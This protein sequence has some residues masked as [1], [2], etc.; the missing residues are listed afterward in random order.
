MLDFMIV[1]TRTGKKKDTVEIYPKFII[2][3]SNDLMIRGGDFYAIWV[4]DKQS[5]STDEQDALRLIDQEVDRYAKENSGRFDGTVKVLHMWDADSGM[6]D[7]WHKYCQKQMRDYFHMLDECLI[8]A[9]TET[10]KEN[11]SSKR[12]PYA[13]QKGDIASYEQLAST[14]YEPEERQKLE[15]AI[16]S[17]VSGDSRHIQKF[18]VLYGSAGTGK[19][20]M[21]NI[22]QQL[23]EG[24]YSVFDAKAL[25]SSN[26]A[27]ALEAFKSNPLVAIQHD[28]DLSRIEDNTR[29]NS[30]VSHELMTVNEK[31][32]STY[33]NNFQCFLFMGTNKP[34]KIT[35]AKSGL[36]RRLIDISPSG[37]KLPAKKYQSLMNQIQFE[38][39]G[40]AQH[41]L[42]VYQENPHRY[43]NYTPI[44]MMGASNDFYNFVLDSYSVFKRENGTTLK[45]AWE[46]YKEYCEDAKVGY[47]MS[48][49]VFKEE[50]RNYFREFED[51]FN[52]EDGSRVRS[53]Y[54]GFRADKFGKDLLPEK[55]Q[56]EEPVTDWLDLKEQESQFDLLCADCQAQYASS[57]EKPYQAWD[58]VTTKLKDLDTRKLHYVRAD[59][60]HIMIDFDRKDAEGKKS[61]VLNKQ[62][63]LKWPPTY[64]ELSKGGEGIH[65]HY[66]YTGDVSKLKNIFDENVEIKV[67]TGKA[68]FRRKLTKCN[69]LAIATISS[70]L[71]ERSKNV[72]NFD[73]IK[74]EEH[75]RNIIKK[76]LRK[77]IHPNTT[78]SVS[79]I[80]QA[81]D[82]AYASG[83]SYDVQDLYDEIFS[84]AANSHHQADACIKAVGEMHFKSEE[85]VPAG[86]DNS[87]DSL[88][89]YDVECFPNLF[90][91][92]LKKQG[93]EYPFYDFYN[94]TPSQ[95]EFILNR[96]LIGFNCKHYDNHMLYGSYLGYNN[97]QMFQLSQGL[98]ND[99]LSRDQKPYFGQAYNI[100]YTDIYD[101]CATK[102]SLKKWEIQ[103]GIHHQELGLPWD[104]PVPKEKWPLVAQY[105]HYDVEATEATWDATQA[106]FLA[107]KILADLAGGTVNDS[108]NSLTGKIIFGNEKNPQ[109]EF[110]YRDLAEPVYELDSE[111]LEFLKEACPEMMESTHGE[112]KSLLPYFPGYTFDKFKKE[113]VYREEI[114]G[115]GGEVYA[116]EGIF[117]WVALLDVASMHPHSAIAEVLFGVR[118]TKIF[119]EIVEGRVS[120]KHKAWSELDRMLGGK[121]KPYIQEV[122]DGK[123]TAKDL[124]YALK[125]AINAVYGQTAAKYPNLFKD[126][127][128][129]DN[130]VAKRGALF[131]IDLKYEVQKR[132]FTVAHIKTDSIKIPNATPEIIQ[133]VMWFGKRYGYTFE[134]EATY[135]KMCLV[136]DAVY[137]AKYAK[138]EDCEK[139][140]GYIPGDNSD[141]GGEWTATG[142][143]FQIPYVFKSLF[144]KEPFDFKDLCETKSVKTYIYL[145]M[146]EDFPDVTAQEKELKKMETKYRKGELSDTTITDIRKQLEPEIEKGH[147]YKFVGKVG[148]FCPMK[149]G[150]GGGLLVR[151]SIGADGR[152]KYD[153]VTGTKGFR[154]MESEMVRELHKENDIDH[155]YYHDLCN[156]A[157]AAINKYG[158]FTWFAS[159]DLTRLPPPTM[160]EWMNIPEEIEGEE[161]PFN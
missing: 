86:L 93:K 21:L 56:E 132:G 26:N 10:K 66:I 145:D 141:H 149:P 122:I 59:L 82:D 146:N 153:A 150:S 138:P 3:K 13:L 16:G 23:F 44:H 27:F 37:K 120:I 28:G 19:S 127:R 11:Y 98:V 50:L 81:L 117:T 157:I 25:G 69:D 102:Q 45:A 9:N 113:S 94:P 30:L 53:Y 1:A 39:G 104:Q 156:E 78:P 18:V 129:I 74:D 76:A 108:T 105:C 49:R 79:M 161:I 46:M 89:F 29:L 67:C 63:A 15:W 143:Q 52:G 125:I 121:L 133:F 58:K 51:R 92:S 41:C 6:V 116:E 60:Q 147:Y 151:E 70:G 8:F 80:K 33:Q 38:L 31:F 96:K 75:L 32:K 77:E 61:F 144:T 54:S 136:N 64:A 103:L 140:Y 43:D 97:D 55:K 107:R 85:P 137:V 131:M 42:E 62:E 24:Y 148:Q 95:I 34:V 5:W 99:D 119:R 128:N 91:I 4:E 139:L 100:S 130:I 35:D 88:W 71:P 159:D 123:Y 106:D 135:E 2:K 87:D 72:V 40:I 68:S 152:T 109:K 14:L 17:I 47:P 101:Y 65:L 90:F 155:G 20:T 114:V 57:D 36:I 142:T 115:E 22:I 124:A 12:L 112:A 110:H 134:H 154:W 160:N 158:D 7:R 84:F 111:S 73:A 118:F 83:I 48:K 126:D